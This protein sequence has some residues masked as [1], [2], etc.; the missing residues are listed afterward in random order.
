MLGRLMLIESTV[1]ELTAAFADENLGRAIVALTALLGEGHSPQGRA[2]VAITQASAA[3]YQLATAETV[4]DVA[5]IASDAF[6]AF[7]ES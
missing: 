4:L 3:A 1:T 2:L 6:R 5:A 7:L